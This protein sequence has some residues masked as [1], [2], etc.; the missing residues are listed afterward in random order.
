MA[1]PLRTWVFI[2]GQNC[3]HDARRAFYQEED[4]RLCGQIDPMA[5]G[6]LLVEK[7]T[8]NDGRERSLERVTIYKGM[9]SSKHDSRS[10]GAY[11]RQ[12]SVWI[13]RGTRVVDR[14][15]RYPEDYPKTPAVEK[16]VDVALAV[17]LVYNGL[18]RFYD[19][20]IVFSTDTDLVPALE[21]M[22]ELRRA[23]GEP[24]LEVATWA[25]TRK[26]LRVDGSPFWCHQLAQADYER[27]RDQTDYTAPKG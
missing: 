1:G 9:P 4:P 10:Y 22:C 21:A 11:R 6:T 16:G 2:D 17:D 18:R 12:K 19:L 3:Y 15:I 5:L 8:A 25:P 14:P 26:R 7:G 13:G 24:R 27:V 20:A 23:W